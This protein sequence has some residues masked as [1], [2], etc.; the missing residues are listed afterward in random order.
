MTTIILSHGNYREL[1]SYQ[2]L[3]V[4]V[5][6]IWARDSREAR[7]VRKLGEDL[8]LLGVRAAGFQRAWNKI[9]AAYSFDRPIASA[10]LP[11]RISREQVSHWD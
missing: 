5:F 8:T 9:M 1:L 4:C 10:I 11:G 3:R 2:F 6:E 7:Y